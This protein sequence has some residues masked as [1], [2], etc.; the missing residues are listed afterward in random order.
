LWLVKEAREKIIQGIF[1]D[2]KNSIIS[3]LNNKL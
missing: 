2:W 3:K 1:E